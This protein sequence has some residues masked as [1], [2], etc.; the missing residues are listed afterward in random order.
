MVFTIPGG[1]MWANREWQVLPHSQSVPNDRDRRRGGAD[2]RAGHFPCAPARAAIQARHYTTGPHSLHRNHQVG[3]YH[4]KRDMG[5]LYVVYCLLVFLGI[6]FLQIVVLLK[7]KER[8]CCLLLRHVYKCGA[9]SKR[10]EQILNILFNLKIM[11]FN[12]FILN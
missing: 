10:T 7:H 1:Y 11:M 8:C 4:R 5:R 9:L 2:W 3:H 12:H 6:A